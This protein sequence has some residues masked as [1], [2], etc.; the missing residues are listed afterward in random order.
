MIMFLNMLNN[1][2]FQKFNWFILIF[3]KH[4]KT[5]MFEIIEI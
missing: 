5:L 3:L 1:E 4:W 2:D